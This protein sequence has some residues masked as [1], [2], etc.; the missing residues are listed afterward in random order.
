[1]P[2]GTYGHGVCSVCGTDRALDQ[3]GMVRRHR[4]RGSTETGPLAASRDLCLGSF[5]APEGVAG[6]DPF[7]LASSA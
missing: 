6:V 2:A 1:M 5:E 7:G 4:R 3:E